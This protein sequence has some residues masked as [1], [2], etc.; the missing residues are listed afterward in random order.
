M[1]PGLT[2]QVIPKSGS[3]L[4]YHILYEHAYSNLS[5]SS[6]VSTA[7]FAQTG[8]FF[9]GWPFLFCMLRVK[10][11][12]LLCGRSAMLLSLILD[13]CV[14]PILV[15]QRKSDWCKNVNC[16]PETIKDT[17]DCCLMSF[18][19]EHFFQLYHGENNLSCTLDEMMIM[20]TLY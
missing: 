20:S 13:E 15:L 9:T 5:W 1:F 19:N 14:A 12:I 10:W 18:L 8:H 16:L 4:I 7:N 2:R 6:F 17:S 11:P 3:H